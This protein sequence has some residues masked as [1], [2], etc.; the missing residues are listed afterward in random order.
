VANSLVAEDLED[1]YTSEEVDTIIEWE[2]EEINEKLSKKS[3]VLNAGDNVI[4]TT[5][6]DGSQTISTGWIDLFVIVDELPVT[7]ENNKIYLVSS[8]SEEGN[9]FAEYVRINWEWES[10]GEISIDFSNFYTKGQV[11]WLISGK[12]DK[13]I[14]INWKALNANITLGASD[15]WL[16][17]VTNDKQAKDADVDVNAVANKI[18]KRDASGNIKGNYITWTWLQ[19]TGATEKTD[20]LPLAV[21]DPSWWVYKQSLTALMANLSATSGVKWLNT[22]IPYLTSTLTVTEQERVLI[23]TPVRWDIFYCKWATWVNDKYNQPVMEF[24]TAT[25]WFLY[26]WYRNF[27]WWASSVSNPWALCYTT[28]T[29]ASSTG[30]FTFDVKENYAYIP[31]APYVTTEF[32]LRV[33]TS[34]TIAGVPLTANITKSQ[35][36]ILEWLTSGYSIGAKRDLDTLTINWIYWVSYA[37]STWTKPPFSSI[38][39]FQLLVMSRAT[40]RSI[41]VSFSHYVDEIY[42]RRRENWVW[43]NWV[44]VW[45]G[46]NTNMNEI[47]WKV[48]NS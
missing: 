31:S 44:K 25:S 2:V 12:T 21:I 5:N 34:R 40:E 24:W 36:G 38:N 22:R 10:F 35:L 27:T 29:Y 23:W 8:S 33:P 14:T 30:V 26:Y 7:G 16:W 17:S 42:M 37:T 43:K 32:A 18:V 45:W 11:D 39:D 1:Y 46:G 47:I 9:L 48:K 41:Q 15:I 6:E 20:A 4:I 28:F 3:P 19:T 13:T